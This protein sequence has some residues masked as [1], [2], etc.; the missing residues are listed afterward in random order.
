M[1]ETA[2]VRRRQVAP[3]RPL[4]VLFCIERKKMDILSITPS[5]FSFSN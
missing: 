5:L 4:S 2:A 1:P 3:V